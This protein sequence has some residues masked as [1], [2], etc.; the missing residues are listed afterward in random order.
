MA[1][2]QLA[3]DYRDR[4]FRQYL[5]FW[6]KGGIDRQFGGFLCELNDDGS[7][8]QDEKF[9]WY[10]GRGLWVYSFLYQHFG[11]QPQWLEVARAAREFLVR[12]MYAGAGRWREKVRRD[13]SV[14]V[15]E[16]RN[17]YGA[18]FA[19]LGLVEY[20]R[21]T[22]SA[23]D[24]ELVKRSL[25]AA[26]RAY[27]AADYT[28]A[29]TA[30]QS[31]AAVPAQGPRI[32]GH[33]M[34]FLTVL[35]RLLERRADADLETLRRA[36]LAAVRDKFWNPDYG[37]A[38]EFLRHDYGRDPQCAAHMFA[39]HTLETL[40][41]V[42]WEALR[43]NDPALFDLAKRRVRRVLEVCWDPICDGFA[44]EDYFVF[45]TPRHPRGPTYDVKTMWAQCEAMIA[46]MMVIEQTAEPWAV[47]WYERVRAFTL[48]TMP[49]AGH[50]VWRQAVN[51]QGH[52]VKRGG[53]S[54]KRK[55]NYHQVRYLMLN[56]LS[57]ER[58]LAT[59]RG[60]AGR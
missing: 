11:R 37:I 13:G 55:D 31:R 32:Q 50:G 29:D 24:L 59:L 49:V 14:M 54:T 44:D 45:G 9:I 53:I 52:D 26:A 41:M 25:W 35:S 28:D 12:H 15:A 58:M 42:M 56:L 27:D 33:S 48:K 8:A 3:D 18:L 16:G 46:C 23:E 22:G 47:E 5:P 36:H 1:I 10:Q 20:Y 4:L 2:A 34:V 21:V 38:N 57:L 43:A 40:W 6:D 17:V 19:A 30:G 39:G 51:R 60:A 7:V